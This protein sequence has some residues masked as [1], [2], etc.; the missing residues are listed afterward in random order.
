MC[1]VRLAHNEKVREKITNTVCNRVPGAHWP[2]F[3]WGDLVGAKHEKLYKGFIMADILT[4]LRLQSV[5]SKTGLSKSAIYAD[6]KEGAFP[7]PYRIG[8]RS[9]AWKSTEIDEWIESRV[10]TSKAA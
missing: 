8:D 10:K 5:K 1:K 4:F 2:V 6:M 3:R 9:V 7:S